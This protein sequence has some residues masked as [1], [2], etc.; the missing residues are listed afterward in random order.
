M[1]LCLKHKYDRHKMLFFFIDTNKINLVEYLNHRIIFFQRLENRF[2]YLIV[3]NFLSNSSVPSKNRQKKI[4]KFEK[5]TNQF[6]LFP[7][8]N[9]EG[10]SN[11]TL[12]TFLFLV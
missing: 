1:L 9:S 5:A 7:F 2:L 3:S 8:V 11:F 6:S 12:Q 10:S 4:V